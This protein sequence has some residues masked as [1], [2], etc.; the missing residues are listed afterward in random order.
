ML[1]PIFVGLG[2]VDAW[3]S[4]QKET[5]LYPVLNPHIWMQTTNPKHQ[6]EIHYK[7]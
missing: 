2:S 4:E 7:Y 1:H 6:F 5:V 3:L